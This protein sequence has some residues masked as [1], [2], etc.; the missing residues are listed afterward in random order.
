[1]LAKAVKLHNFSARRAD[2]VDGT[3]TPR[4]FLEDCIARIDAFEPTVKAFVYLDLKAARAAADESTARYRHRSAFS[5]I[6]GCPVGIKD[7]I[8]TR[9]MPTGYGSPAFAN[10]QTSRDAA[11][12]LALRMSG[13]VP[14]GKTVTTEFAI[15][16]SGVTTNPHDE[17]RT[18]GGS[19][20]GS[21]AAVAAGMVPIALGTQTMGSILRPASYTGIFGYKG[22]FG[23]LPMGGVH[24]VAGSL[25]HLGLLASN[26]DDLWATASCISGTVGNPGHVPLKSRGPRAPQ[27]RLPKRLIRL[28]LNAWNELEPAHKA[29]FEDELAAF[30]NNGIDIVDRDDVRVRQLEDLLDRSIGTA[31]DILTYEMVWPYSDYVALHGDLI[32]TRIRNVVA[33]QTDVSPEA[34][35]MV[36]TLRESARVEAASTLHAL[37]ASAFILPASSG[38]APKGLEFT[39]SRA[40]VVYWSWLGFPAISV[41]LMEADGLP[42]GLQV[43]HVA[44]RDDDMCAVAAGLLG[45]AAKARQPHA[46]SHG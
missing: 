38:P 35:R 24:P 28:H 19:S 17:S 44:G 1:M 5:P 16:Y 6:D 10:T 11:C 26:L 15:G 33:R 7:I 12:V 34:Y 42:W 40:Y 21:A 22:T 27:A 9:D 20:S 32:G 4:Q 36:L 39:G 43:A 23:S 8:E 14:V 41:P 3:D 2:F 46:L 29:I 31:E 45:A 37:D 13:A 18:P 30:R 25:D